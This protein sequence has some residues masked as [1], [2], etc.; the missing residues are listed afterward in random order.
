LPVPVI[1]S[2]ALSAKMLEIFSSIQGEGLLVG[3]RQIFLRFYGCNLACSYCD[4]ER[5]E[6]PEFCT[7]ES[8]P[9]RRDFI[10]VEN[11]ITIERIIAL[12]D[13]WQ[14]SWP[15]VHHSISITGGEPLLNYETLLDWLP[16]LKIRLP[17]YLETNGMLPHALARLINFL[18][19]ISMDIKIPSTSGYL[20]LWEQ[21]HEFLKIAVRKDVYV[22]TVI[23]EAT[24]N[25]EIIKA[26]K[27][28]SSVDKSIP[29]ILQPLTLISGEIG[30]GPI[31][32]LELQEVASSYLSEVRIIPQTHKM[33]RQL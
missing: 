5:N 18:D 9:G 3:L 28:I 19:Y 2:K 32:T 23:S 25:W 33:L 7:I 13:R 11:P 31:K 4:T 6:C 12:L 20:E 1:M 27:L 30:V 22:K 17:V 15:G 21:H 10:K 29:Y 14:H 16:L 26:C 24:E 8:T